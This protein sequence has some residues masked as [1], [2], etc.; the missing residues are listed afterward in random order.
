MTGGPEAP[1]RRSRQA[2]RALDARTQDILRTLLEGAEPLLPFATAVVLQLDADPTRVAAREL[3]MG[4][5]A[6]ILRAAREPGEALPV[7]LLAADP[8]LLAS[9]FQNT[10]LLDPGTDE[11]AAVARMV[12]A[13]L[14]RI[15]DRAL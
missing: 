14:E 3:T 10:D 9:F 2:P 6:E 8:P 12:M 1:R 11:T 15:D 7:D 5:L 4:R 13:A